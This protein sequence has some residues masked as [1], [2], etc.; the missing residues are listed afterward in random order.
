MAGVVG[1]LLSNSPV[2]LFLLKLLL[3]LIQDRFLLSSSDSLFY[4]RHHNVT[5]TRRCPSNFHS[6]RISHSPDGL[7]C[8]DVC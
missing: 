6:S 8:I 4:T 2:I 7:L 1:T 5:W 3:S